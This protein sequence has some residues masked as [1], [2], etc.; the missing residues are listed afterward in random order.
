MPTTKSLLRKAILTLGSSASVDSGKDEIT[1]ENI[2]SSTSQ[3]NNTRTH[4][5]YTAPFDGIL[6]AFLQAKR[7]TDV[8][9]TYPDPGVSLA[10]NNRRRV[11]IRTQD[12]GISMRLAKG[13]TVII[14]TY[15]EGP[16]V[17]Q[18]RIHLYKTKGGGLIGFFK[19]LLSQE[20]RYVFN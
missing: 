9:S 11:A 4:R 3:S 5:Q 8:A 13:D 12:G 1:I 18:R 15:D 20:V 10:Y 2:T 16:S 17:S 7:R 14:Q 19:N 6:Y